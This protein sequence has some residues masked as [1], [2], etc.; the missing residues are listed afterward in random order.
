[1]SR[2]RSARCTVVLG[3]DAML[4]RGVDQ[5]VGEVGPSYPLDP[6]AGLTRTAGA[7]LVNLECALTS[8]MGRFEG[9]RKAFCF[10]ARPAAADVLAR[11]GVTAVSLANNHALDAG[12]DAVGDTL[13][14]LGARG[15]AAAGAG[16]HLEA[17]RRSVVIER[18]GLRLGLVAWCDHEAELAAGTETAG[19]HHVDVTDRRALHRLAREIQELAGT[20][21]HVIVACHWLPNWVPRLPGYYRLLAALLVEAGASLIWG[22]SPHHFLG[23]EWIGR[24]AALYSTGD[25]VSDYAVDRTYRNDR[26]LLFEATLDRGGVTEVRAFPLELEVARTQPARPAARRWIARRFAEHCRE[27]GSRVEEQGAWLAVVSEAA[28]ARGSG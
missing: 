17:A 14:L 10:R 22:H 28:A 23:V 11:A 1:M 13:A 21:D 8:D 12:R 27:V 18:G 19:I 4:G 24:A 16:S 7:F 6:I 5:V 20:V 25:L 26:Q 9:P 3:G 2:R 15:I